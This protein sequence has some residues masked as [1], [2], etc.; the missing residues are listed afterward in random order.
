MKGSR[1]PLR[2]KRRYAPQSGPGIAWWATR[3]ASACA[4]TGAT[5]AWKLAIL[6]LQSALL[7]RPAKLNLMSWEILQN[8]NRKALHFGFYKDHFGTNESIVKQV[9][10][11]VTA[12][13]KQSA[14]QEPEFLNIM[15]CSPGECSAGALWLMFLYSSLNSP[16]DPVAGVAFG[17]SGTAAIGCGK[18]PSGRQSNNLFSPPWRLKG[19]DFPI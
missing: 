10:F 7:Q 14:L 5:I 15:L 2:K 19:G 9:P 16:N 1:S 17:P 11:G 4:S 3:D 13:C 8:R 12:L 6:E 18:E